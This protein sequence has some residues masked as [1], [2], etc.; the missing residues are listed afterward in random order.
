MSGLSVSSVVR[1][2]DL[3]SSNV[4]DMLCDHLILI[5]AGNHITAYNAVISHTETSP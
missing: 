2:K 4:S 3:V 1:G 5:H